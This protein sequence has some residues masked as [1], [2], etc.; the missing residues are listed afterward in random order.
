[1]ARPSAQNVEHRDIGAMMDVEHQD[2]DAIDVEHQ[3]DGATDFD[4]DA[5]AIGA[6]PGRGEAIG[7]GTA[8]PLPD[9]NK[10]SDTLRSSLAQSPKHGRRYNP[11]HE[12]KRPENPMLIALGTGGFS[13][14][15]RG[16]R[17]SRHAKLEQTLLR[18]SR[19]PSC[20][21][22][23]Q[24]GVV[25]INEHRSSC[26][27]PRDGA[28]MDYVRRPIRRGGWKGDPDD[29]VKGPGGKTVPIYR[30]LTRPECGFTFHRD[31]VCS[32]NSANHTNAAILGRGRPR[33]FT[34]R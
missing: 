19:V 20:N 21:N 22:H 6:G 12:Y 9:M 2:D 31:A 17:A 14:N 16:R 4:E 27:C 13:T 28:K 11:P 8:R 23:V 10:D 18:R 26:L 34:S 25:G 1:V 33:C 24:H 30:L 29:I 15:S 32:Q 3:D 5:T 7:P